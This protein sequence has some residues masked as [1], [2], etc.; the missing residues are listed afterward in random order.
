LD[1][2]KQLIVCSTNLMDSVRKT[3]VASEVAS[4]RVFRTAA[5]AAVAAVKFRKALYKKTASERN[6]KN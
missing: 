5:N 6:M 2:E 3:L 1:S 4:I